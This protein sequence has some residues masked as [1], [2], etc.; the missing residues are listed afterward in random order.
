MQFITVHYRTNCFS[1]CSSWTWLTGDQRNPPS[2][3][4]IDDLPATVKIE[5]MKE[6]LFYFLTND[7]LPCNQNEVVRAANRMQVGKVPVAISTFSLREVMTL[8]GDNISN[9]FLPVWM[10]DY[11]RKYAMLTHY[12]AMVWQ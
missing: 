9:F 3:L 5:A 1:I 6:R 8:I 2:L 10:A 4:S 7:T 11:V 12:F